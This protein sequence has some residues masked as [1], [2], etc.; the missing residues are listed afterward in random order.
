MR[1]LNEIDPCIKSTY[2][3]E[4]ENIA[5]LAAS[6]RNSEVINDL[7]VKPT[8]RHQSLQ[9]FLFIH[10]TLKSQLSLAKLFASVSLVIPR[11]IFKIIIKEMKSCF[12]KKEYPED[13]ISSDMRK[14]I[15]SNFK[16]NNNDSNNNKNSIPII[17]YYVL[18]IAEIS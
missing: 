11:C 6:L 15:F 7:S 10:T 12:W 1:S 3:T 14:A 18:S 2:E 13:L 9:Y 8:D 4:K 5:F 17:N 16:I